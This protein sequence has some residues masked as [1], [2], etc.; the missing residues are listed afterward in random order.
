MK[1]IQITV[2]RPVATTLM[3]AAM[4]ITT[5]CR[6]SL[7]TSPKEM[8]VVTTS[9][10]VQS[11]STT[12]FNGFVDFCASEP[13]TNFKITPGGTLH[14]LGANENRWVTGNPLIDGV[15]QNTVL[16]NI[17]LKQGT[18]DVH[19]DLSLKPDAVEGTWEI[20]QTVNIR[21]GAPAGSSGVGHG[22]GDL[23]GLTIKFTTEPGVAGDNIC[24]ADMPV[25]PVHG[26]ILSPA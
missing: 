10:A 5:G 22:T 24:N 26:E 14:F 8:S 19:L 12:E 13:P 25:A 11:A 2:P 3:A 21:D 9:L 4:I 7:P 6:D 17:N 1:S 16:A 20:R 15:E 18:G 23:Q